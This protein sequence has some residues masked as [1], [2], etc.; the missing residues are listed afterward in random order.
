MALT[1]LLGTSLIDVTFPQKL[2]SQLCPE[3]SFA[4]QPG[5]AGYITYIFHVGCIAISSSTTV[6][7]EYPDWPD[8][9]MPSHQER[10]QVGISMSKELI[11]SFRDQSIDKRYIAHRKRNYKSYD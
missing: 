7:P 8:K 5:V 2:N 1:S 10:Y 3:A 6:T 11:G 9:S 4:C